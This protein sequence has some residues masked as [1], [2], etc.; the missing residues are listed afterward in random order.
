MADSALSRS[1]AGVGR[2]T[3]LRAVHVTPPGSSPRVLL[4][5]VHGVPDVAVTRAERRRRAEAAL[6][7]RDTV[8]RLLVEFTDRLEAVFER[9]TVLWLDWGAEAERQAV[10]GETDGSAP[11][12]DG[13][14][15]AEGDKAKGE[16]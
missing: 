3:S 13:A 9:G 4:R 11:G 14:A 1:P 12:K 6:R 5:P 10:W 15:T 7:A 2:W 8:P 16:G